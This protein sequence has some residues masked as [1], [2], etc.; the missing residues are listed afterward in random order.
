MVR[1]NNNSENV[2]SVSCSYQVYGD[3]TPLR[4]AEDIA[5]NVALFIAKKNGSFINYYMVRN[6]RNSTEDFS[7]SLF[8]ILLKDGKQFSFSLLKIYIM[9]G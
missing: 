9:H 4:S 5:F 8:I 3:K 6:K 2:F 1:P 7:F